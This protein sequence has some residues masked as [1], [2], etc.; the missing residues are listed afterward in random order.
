MPQDKSAKKSGIT[1][2]S[3]KVGDLLTGAYNEARM[4]QVKLAQLT[5]MST[6]TLQKK[7]AGKA[8]ISTTD[9]AL[10]AGAIPGVEAGTILETAI[11]R[12]GGYKALLSEATSTTED[13][14][15]RRKQAGARAMTTEQI[16]GLT[17]HAASTT[18]Q[19]HRR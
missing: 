11:S 6:V 4:N 19:K 14:D 8:P 2:L 10:I 18:K 16:E 12:L 9:L 5:G 15:R 1:P 3:I 13:A 17:N 7:L